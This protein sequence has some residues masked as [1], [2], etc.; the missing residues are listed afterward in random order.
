MP[1]TLEIRDINTLGDLGRALSRFS[2]DVHRALGT[3]EKTID[4]T[5][6][7]LDERTRHWQREATRAHKTVEQAR[8]DLGR[9]ESS[10][11]YDEDG[12]Y[13]QPNCSSER[14][15]LGRA[16]DHLLKCE[17]NLHD[18][19]AWRS[20]VNK[21]I[22][23]YRRQSRRL[24][25]VASNHTERAQAELSKLRSRY[26]AV[27]QRQVADGIAGALVGG[28]MA[29]VAVGSALVSQVH[30]GQQADVG[31]DDLRPNATYHHGGYEFRTDEHGW[32]KSVSGKLDLKTGK[33]NLRL[34][35]QV[36][37]MG[38]PTDVGGHLIGVRFNGPSDAYN[39]IPQDADLNNKAWKRMENFW[40]SSLESGNEVRVK[41]EPI[42]HGEGVRP[43]AIEA[44]YQIDRGDLIHVLFKNRSG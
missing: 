11:Y 17:E 12:H 23:G 26:E 7:W 32:P 20:R 36:G 5:L 37:K 19:Q 21:A 29:V 39:L 22:D 14:A 31:V 13:H 42:R 8:V 15:Q 34:Q 2:T 25:G 28:T 10:G 27:H 41:I 4:D 18:A 43:V 3:A 16:Q 44:T 35:R 38:R 40:A 24:E 6:G 9:C 1:D 30:S 33:R